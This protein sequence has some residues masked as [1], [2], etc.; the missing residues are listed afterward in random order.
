MRCVTHIHMFWSQLPIR[1]RLE[2]AEVR[3]KPPRRPG[4]VPLEKGYS[5][6]DWLRLCRTHPDV[7]GVRVSGLLLCVP[8]CCPNT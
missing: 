3:A 7:A 8:L 4:K 6:M 5:Q 2:Q 1:Q